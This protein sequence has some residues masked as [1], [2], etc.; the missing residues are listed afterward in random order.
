MKPDH[1][2]IHSYTE[3][4][5]ILNKKKTLKCLEKKVEWF[6]ILMFFRNYNVSSS[7]YIK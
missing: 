5:N 4:A 2:N 6:F 3:E 1:R 7:V